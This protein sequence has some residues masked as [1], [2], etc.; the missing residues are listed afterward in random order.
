MTPEEEEIRRIEEIVFNYLFCN[1]EFEQSWNNKVNVSLRSPDGKDRRNVG[2][3][4][5]G[6]LK[7]EY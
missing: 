2:T 4:Y 5:V 6:E 1:L 7:D 3:F